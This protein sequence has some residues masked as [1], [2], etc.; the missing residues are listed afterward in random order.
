[1]AGRVRLRE[2]T[3]RDR[4]EEFAEMVRKNLLEQ[5]R[6]P[7][8]FV[9][10]VGMLFMVI[11]MFSFSAASFTAPPGSPRD[12][13]APDPS[14]LGGTMFY[15]FI[16]FAFLS[17]ALW[18]IGFSIREE[19]VRGTL[20]T[21]YM[22]PA[23]KFSQLLARVFG[24]ILLSGILSIIGFGFITFVLGPLPV[25]N[26]GFGLVVF[27]FALLGAVGIGFM[28]AAVT[29]V[30]KATVNHLIQFLQFFFMIG[31]AMFF[32]FRVLPPWMVDGVSRWI[33]VSY[34]VDLFRSTLMGAAPELLPWQSEFAIVAAFGIISPLLGYW[35]YLKMEARARE[36]G[37]LG[38][39]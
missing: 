38:E 10:G 23:S 15:G 8:E 17:S 37:K 39:F 33:P 27:F 6:Y 22:S 1:M 7:I 28:L 21:L 30:A 4:Y 14:S 35:L 24:T 12:P 18:N 9:A 3:L 5:S 2:I 25:Q 31:C 32:P 29:L 20:E 13:N 16:L 26:L 19:Q 11:L 36:Q 34:S